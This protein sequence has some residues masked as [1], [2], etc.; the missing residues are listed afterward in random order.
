MKIGTD[1]TEVKKFYKKK[2]AFYKKLF[3]ESEINYAKKYKNYAERFAGFFCVKEATMKALGQGYDIIRFIDI[4]TL[5]LECGKPFI[6]LKETAKK[7]FEEQGGKKIE[8]SIS[9]TNDI[10]MAVVLIKF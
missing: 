3:T 4:E 8:I 2:E 7:S 6:N 5:H 1:L 10:A 9:H